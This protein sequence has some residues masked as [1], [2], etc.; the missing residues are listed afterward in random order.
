MKKT[1]LS[2][3]LVFALLFAIMA[4][5]CSNSEAPAASG[6]AK[7]DASAAGGTESDATGATRTIQTVKGP[8]EVPENPQRIAVHYLEGDVLALG[9]NIV[10]CPEPFKGCAFE[11]Q[12]EGVNFVGSGAWDPEEIMSFDPDLI[13]VIIEEDYDKMSSIAPTIF[14]PFTGM[15]HAERLGFL[16]EIMGKE[17]E[18]KALLTAYDDKIKEANERIKSERPE[19]LERTISI[20]EL[21]EAGTNMIV[22]DRWGRGGDII[23]N[24][25]GF[26]PTPRVQTEI[27]DA[28]DTAYLMISDEVLPEYMG[29][30][31]FVTI[32][33][34]KSGYEDSK[35]WESLPAVQDGYVIPLDFGM[36]YYDDI[37]SQNAQ[38][39]AITD[40]IL[41]VGK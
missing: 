26:K 6:S 29:D 34:G 19:M 21:W 37:L 7:S 1:I 30:A 10:A 38:L 31:I 32:N 13:I 14:I 24:K 12:L 36:F 41:G 23:Y 20:V 8:V 16:G 15:S 40:G 9:G 22:G 2:A 11:A 18:A 25:L 5:G 28:E 17:D 4:A 27:F 33:E 3:A 35:V 39:Q